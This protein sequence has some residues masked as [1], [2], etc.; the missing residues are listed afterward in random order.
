MKAYSLAK[1][2]YRDNKFKFK[3]SINIFILSK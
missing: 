2:M 1:F 3:Y